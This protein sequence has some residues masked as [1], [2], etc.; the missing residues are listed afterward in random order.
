M[1]SLLILLF[2]SIA[3]IFSMLGLGGGIFYVP[4][5]LN[6]GI[7][8]HQ[9]VPTSLAIMAVMSLTATIIYHNEKLIDWQIFF[10]IEPFSIIGAFIGSYNSKFLPV[11]FLEILFA[12]IMFISAILHFLPQTINNEKPKINHF[13]IIHKQ[14]NNSFYSINLWFGIPISFLAGLVSS[15]IGIGGGFAKLPLMT[16]IFKTPIKVAAATS[17]AMIVLTSLTGLLGHSLVGNVNKSLIVPLSLAVF[18]GAITG[19]KIAIKAN[20]NFLN[21]LLAILQ[22]FIGLWLIFK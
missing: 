9:A 7:S 21:I 10:T 1:N 6:A 8:F 11:R 20:R 22:I 3:I 13:G 17:S 12:I 5:L 16:L 19:S 2:F 18:F 15:I 4:I 14:H